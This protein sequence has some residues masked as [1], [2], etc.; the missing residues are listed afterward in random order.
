MARYNKERQIWAGIFTLTGLIPFLGLGYYVVKDLTQ[1]ITPNK[2][3]LAYKAYSAIILA[4][5]GGIH[6]GLALKNDQIHSVSLYVSSVLISLIAWLSLTLDYNKNTLLALVAGYGLV[7]M[8]DNWLFKSNIIQLWFL[9]MRLL[10]TTLVIMTHI[11]IFIKLIN[12]I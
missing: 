3:L 10:A 1:P 2:A 6:W 12:T 9:K 4:F 7:L 11:L 8:I 5:L